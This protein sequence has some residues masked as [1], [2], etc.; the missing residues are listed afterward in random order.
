[1]IQRELR[2]WSFLFWVVID[3]KHR[4]VACHGIDRSYFYLKDLTAFKKGWK[5]RNGERGE[6]YMPL[7]QII[8]VVKLYYT[9]DLLP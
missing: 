1:M 2:C 3:I 9:L 6:E 8:G 5:W 4:F 7:I